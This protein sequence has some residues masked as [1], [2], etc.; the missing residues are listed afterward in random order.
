MARVLQFLF[1]SFREQ[2]F[3]LFFIA[4]DFRFGLCTPNLLFPFVYS[5]LMN[6]FF[7]SL[8][9]IFLKNHIKEYLRWKII[10]IKFCIF[11]FERSWDI[12]KHFF[13]KGKKCKYRDTFSKWK[14]IKMLLHFIFSVIVSL[15]EINVVMI[16]SEN[17]DVNFNDAFIKNY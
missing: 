13:Y 17:L 10:W 12:Y 16:L 1:T 3:L 7:N 8:M 4:S 15:K 2:I 9:Q 6:I 11:L 5:F 14:K